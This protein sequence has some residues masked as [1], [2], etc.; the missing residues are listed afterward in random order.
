LFV[1]FFK[2]SIWL[3][4]LSSKKV[5]KFNMNFELARGRKFGAEQ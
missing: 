1:F 3:S 5:E 4:R 2:F